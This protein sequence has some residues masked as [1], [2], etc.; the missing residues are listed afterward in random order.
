MKHEL[1]SI[2]ESNPAIPR[3]SGIVRNSAEFPVIPIRFNSRN[4]VRGM[5]RLFYRLVFKHNG[6]SKGEGGKECQCGISKSIP[7]IPELQGILGDS[8]IVRNCLNGFRNSWESAES[9]LGLNGVGFDPVSE[10]V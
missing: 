1:H 6:K 4:S 8:R 9:I 5:A 3:K 2:P 10:S 7:A